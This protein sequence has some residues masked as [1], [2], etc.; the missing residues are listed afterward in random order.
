MAPV[1]LPDRWVVLF[2]VLVAWLMCVLYVVGLG[3][4]D[5]YL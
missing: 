5:S 4:F 2:F 3:T 1:L